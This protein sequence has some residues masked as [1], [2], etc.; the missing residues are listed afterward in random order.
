M[1][2]RPFLNIA[3]TPGTSTL[4]RLLARGCCSEEAPLHLELENHW[5]EALAP[6]CAGP[7]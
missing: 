4:L 7:R 1:R 2:H 3:A 6:G 5:E